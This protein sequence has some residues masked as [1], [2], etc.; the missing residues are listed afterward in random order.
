[1]CFGAERSP[2]VGVL[3]DFVAVGGN[4]V[5]VGGAAA[6]APALS[7][8]AF[9]LFVGHLKTQAIFSAAALEKTCF[10]PASHHR[11]TYPSAAA[12]ARR[13]K[14]QPCFHPCNLHLPLLCFV[15]L[16]RLLLD[17]DGGSGDEAVILTDILGIEDALGTM[18]F[19]VA[20]NEHGEQG[21]HLL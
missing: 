8:V 1:M 10:P 14:S 16:Y 4:V 19:K 13:F 11:T 21:S 7:T 17:E 12:A 2:V 20:G 5:V 15:L 3:V 18:D 6:R 9:L